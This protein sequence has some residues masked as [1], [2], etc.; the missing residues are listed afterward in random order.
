MLLL[1]VWFMTR[2]RA[3]GRAGEHENNYEKTFR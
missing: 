2:V 3:L 1:R